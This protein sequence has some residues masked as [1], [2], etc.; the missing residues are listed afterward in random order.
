MLHTGPVP[1]PWLHVETPPAT[2]VQA[3]PSSMVHVALQPSPAL[4]P[5]SSH[6]SMSR[7]VSPSPHRAAGPSATITSMS[8]PT[9]TTPSAAPVPTIAPEERPSTRTVNVSPSLASGRST[10]IVS[11]V[12]ESMRGSLGS[13]VG[14][15]AGAP[16]SPL[17]SVP[18]KRS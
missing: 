3:Q 9:A 16:S 13:I 17:A 18:V 6:A 11:P 15:K 12:A 2:V 1:Q 4:V 10:T 14:V 7:N 8:R 5:P